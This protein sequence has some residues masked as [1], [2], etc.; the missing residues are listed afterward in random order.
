VSER[1]E[2]G[3]EEATKKR[4]G[5]KKKEVVVVEKTGGGGEDSNF[6]LRKLR[7]LSLEQA[8]D[9]GA[10]SYP[11]FSHLSAYS[12]LRP[13][14]FLLLGS[15]RKPWSASARG[16]E[17]ACWSGERMRASVV[18]GRRR[19]IFRSGEGGRE[20]LTGS[21]I[22]MHPSRVAPRRRPSLLLLGANARS[23][24]VERPD[25]PLG[26]G[27][28]AEALQKGVEEEKESMSKRNSLDRK[29]LLLVVVV[30]VLPRPF[31]ALS[32]VRE[33]PR[34]GRRVRALALSLLQAREPALARE[35][36]RERRR[37]FLAV[38]RRSQWKFLK[39]AAKRR[40]D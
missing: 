21:A 20:R 23:Q 6:A 14:L 30:V 8:L 25:G 12:P 24:H 27:E 40:R 10:L 26:G 2:G 17:V 35:R 15:C 33:G 13:S 34:G 22:E 19:E 16:G 38:S 39:R 37:R 18:R 5:K 11:P 29:V 7:A 1:E 31:L 4:G 3:E 28:S 9:G 32:R 36:E